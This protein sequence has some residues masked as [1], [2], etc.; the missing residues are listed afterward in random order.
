MKIL[1][2]IHLRLAGKDPENLV[3][4]IRGSS[5]SASELSEARIYRHS[6]LENDLAIHLHRDA[7]S[8]K[9]TSDVGVRL[10]AVLKEIGMVSHSV[11]TECCSLDNS[12]RPDETFEKQG[13]VK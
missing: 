11:W 6:R 10:A 3:D 12:S 8:D 2:I 1:E 5:G 4:I 7:G 13:G 9:G